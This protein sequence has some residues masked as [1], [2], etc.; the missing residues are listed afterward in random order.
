MIKHKKMI[1]AFVVFTFLSL[2]QI[3]AMPRP[4]EQ[5]PGQAGTSIA[6]PEKAPNFI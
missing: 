4:T 1:A 6:S 3:S 2:L 5:T